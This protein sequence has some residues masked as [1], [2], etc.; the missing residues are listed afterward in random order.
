M[1]LRT[2]ILLANL[3]LIASLS[4][5]ELSVDEDAAT[6]DNRTASNTGTTE[7]NSDEGVDTVKA[8]TETGEVTVTEEEQ[9][10]KPN[11]DPAAEDEMTSEQKLEAL[12]TDRS[13]LVEEL[14]E[15]LGQKNLKEFESS[16]S[17]VIAGE[18]SLAEFLEI[19]E[20]QYIN[21]TTEENQYKVKRLNTIIEITKQQ[22]ELKASLEENDPEIQTLN[23]DMVKRTNTTN[24]DE[25]KK[26]DDQ[27][28]EPEQQRPNCMERV[29]QFLWYPLEGINYLLSAAR[30]RISGKMKLN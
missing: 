28:D 21:P 13:R 4:A 6:K 29:A 17:S 20:E 1:N 15:K 30:Q 10:P 3:M 2:K 24:S 11:V 19:S 5:M 18:T 27:C 25:N 26:S 16:L 23:G 12:A 7:L 9:D 8:K 14:M 22:I